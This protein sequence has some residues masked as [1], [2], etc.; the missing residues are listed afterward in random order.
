MQLIEWAEAVTTWLGQDPRRLL[1][2]LGAIA[3]VT[4]LGS[5]RRRGAT[6]LDPQRAFSAA[7]RHRIHA[8][9]G[10]RCE[11]ESLWW[12]RCPAV[13]THADHIHP[14][15]KGGAS[16][17]ANGASACAKHNLRKGAKVPSAL[18][19][20]RLERRRRKYF[21]PGEPTEVNWRLPSR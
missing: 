5:I 14:H 21:P 15:A 3:G 7:Q 20:W 10:K 13:G 1:V 9:A 12:L 11:L 17:L 2:G 16:S 6:Q 18:A 8:R 4:V 19:I